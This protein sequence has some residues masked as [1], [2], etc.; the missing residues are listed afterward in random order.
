MTTQTTQFTAEQLLRMPDD[1]SRYELIEGELRRMTPA[2]DVH[3]YLALRIASRLERHVD[4]NNLGRTYA[5]ETGFKISSEPDTVRA[6]DAAFVRR[7]RVE[8]AGRV[9]GYWPGAPDLVVEVVSPNDTHSEVIGTS[10]AWL[11][12]GSRMVM[13]VD[14]EKHTVTVYRSRDEI[15]VLTAEAGDTID[16]ADVVPGWKLSVAELFA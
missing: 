15:R 5:S 10:L 11:E 8:K 1:G 3:G 13:V 16:G 12:A 7:E 9:R 14:P 4:A 2:G 6:P